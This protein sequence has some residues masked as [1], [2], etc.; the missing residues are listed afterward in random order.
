[1]NTRHGKKKPAK[2]S[3]PGFV[4]T[5]DR[6]DRPAGKRED[7]QLSR[8][9][10]FQHAE[11]VAERAAALS[12]STADT[13]SVVSKG[14]PY[15]DKLSKKDKK[16]RSDD[17]SVSDD[18]TQS[19]DDLNDTSIV[20]D[21]DIHLVETDAALDESDFRSTVSEFAIQYGVEVAKAFFAIE[22]KRIPAQKKAK[23]SP[24]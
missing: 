21:G 2:Q 14:G 9:G 20:E 8:F 6:T 19:T 23:T 22:M 24:K 16:L 15:S 13:E 7:D 17:D 4:P 5:T 3:K 18:E 1:M 11:K 10:G 12:R